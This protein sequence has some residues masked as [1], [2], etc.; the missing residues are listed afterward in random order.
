MPE[1]KKPEIE[2]YQLAD[3]F[4][5]SEVTKDATISGPDARERQSIFLSAKANENQDSPSDLS[6]KALNPEDPEYALIASNKFEIIDDNAVKPI[7]KKTERFSKP[8]SKESLLSKPLRPAIDYSPL[9]INEGVPIEFYNAVVDA[10]KALPEKERCILESAGISIMCKDSVEGSEGS[11]AVYYHATTSA[12]PQ[13]HIGLT[14]VGESG[15]IQIIIPNKDIPG[16]LKH[17]VGHALFD[18]L[19]ESKKSEFINSF[20]RELSKISSN[21]LEREPQLKNASHIFAE[22]YAAIRG[23]QSPRV[24]F[25]KTYFP[26]TLK[27]VEKML[28]S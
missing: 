12:K 16:S 3:S 21:Y 15:P 28:D 4:E 14:G 6:L 13:I 22:I 23:R 11:P 8:D 7:V 27:L 18:N 1:E 17:E 25:V 10:W 24:E 5:K 20:E 26:E 19:I 2:N 9:I